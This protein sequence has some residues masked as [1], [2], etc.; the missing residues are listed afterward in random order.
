MV[1]AF[2][3]SFE[4]VFDLPTGSS[5]SELKRLTTSVG[6]RRMPELPDKPFVD[7]R[8]VSVSSDEGRYFFLPDP[9]SK[10]V[11]SPFESC[12]FLF[13]GVLLPPAA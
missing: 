1:F 2:V 4:D 10:P 5:S 12:F 13:L 7:P 3:C 9:F 6:L 8:E 11:V